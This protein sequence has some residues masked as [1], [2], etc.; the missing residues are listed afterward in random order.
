MLANVQG[1]AERCY[2]RQLNMYLDNVSGLGSRYGECKSKCL[3]K[4]PELAKDLQKRAENQ[5][6][7][8]EYYNP[9]YGST[10]LS[11][12]R[13]QFYFTFKRVTKYFS[14]EEDRGFFLESSL[15][16]LRHL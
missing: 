15:S 4:D 2:V 5:N 14:S 11:N 10:C 9:M 16:E 6:K 3:E 13:N 8:T 1:Q 12:C 7:S